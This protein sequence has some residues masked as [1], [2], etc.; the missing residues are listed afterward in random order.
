MKV[1]GI[2]IFGNGECMRNTGAGTRS[3]I[4]ESTDNDGTTHIDF[5]AANDSGDYGVRLIREGQNS[6]MLKC[7]CSALVITNTQS[8][9]TSSIELRSNGGPS[10]IDF[11]HDASSDYATRIITYQGD[12]RLHV[13]GGL[14]VDSGTKSAMQTTEHYGNRLMYAVESCE[15]FFEDTYE[16]KL[17]NGE[18]I[19]EMD[20]IF[21]ECVN[22]KDYNYY[23]SLDEWDECEG[24]FAPKASRTPSN[25]LVKEKHN[26]TSNI[27]FS[28]TVRARRK[29]FE[30]IRLEQIENNYE[31][32]THNTKIN[33]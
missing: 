18:C 10:Y 27:E 5:N 25:F 13:A 20:P 24:L 7:L 19:V 9:S 15:N 6:R 4:L 22:T 33:I 21:L 2:H 16:C 32:M 23:L 8:N 11:S 1:Q 14:V 12:S 26:G 29:D 28:V 30:E 31:M 3:L 17:V